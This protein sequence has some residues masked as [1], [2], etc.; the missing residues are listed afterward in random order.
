[1]NK[2][3]KKSSLIAIFLKDLIILVPFFLVSFYLVRIPVPTDIPFWI[4]F[5]ALITAFMMTSVAWIAL[6]MFKA[7]LF[8][9]IAQRDAARSAR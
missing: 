3:G 5:W 7:V 9:Q 8:D 4:N 1:M 6:Q 2:Q